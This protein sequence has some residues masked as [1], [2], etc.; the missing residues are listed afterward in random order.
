MTL[1][2]LRRM[3]LSERVQKDGTERFKRDGTDY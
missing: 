3:A 2:G 1:K